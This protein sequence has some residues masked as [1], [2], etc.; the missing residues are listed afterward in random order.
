MN[1]VSLGERKLTELD[2]GRLIQLP[3]A[4]GVSPLADLLGEAEVLETSRMP[5]DVVTMYAQV[6]VEDL[7][8]RRRSRFV[9]CYP[10][11]TEPRDGY[12]SVLSPVGLALI[13]TR[14][15]TLASWQSPAGAQCQAKVLAVAR[16]A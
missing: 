14:V 1:A 4:R 7:A 16:A 2:Y 9:L 8:S 12:I 10:G 3:A 15:G 5:Q 11:Q 13:G 6:Q